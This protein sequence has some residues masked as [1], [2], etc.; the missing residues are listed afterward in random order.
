MANK[1]TARKTKKAIKNLTAPRGFVMVPKTA[2]AKFN[3][4]IAG[5]NKFDWKAFGT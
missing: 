5:I 3:K 2:L 1:G 4:L